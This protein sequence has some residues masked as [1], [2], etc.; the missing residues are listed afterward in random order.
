MYFEYESKE[1]E[2]LKSRDKLLGEAIE[3]I[4]HIH[5]T[6]DADLFPYGTIANLY[7]LTIAGNA[8]LE[9]SDYAPQ[10]NP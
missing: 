1:I 4:G 2:H 10:K 6:I 8:I 7:L 5:K 3:K 9:M